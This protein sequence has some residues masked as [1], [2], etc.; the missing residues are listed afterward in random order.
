MWQGLKAEARGRKMP[1][2]LDVYEAALSSRGIEGVKE[3]L[4]ARHNQRW[5]NIQRNGGE[6]A[7]QVL[8][9]L[10][11]AGVIQLVAE[12]IGANRLRLPA[13]PYGAPIDHLAWGVDGVTSAC[14]MLLAGQ[15]FGAAA[16]A[17]TQ[18]ERWSFNLAHGLGVEFDFNALGTDQMR[19]LWDVHHLHVDIADIWNELSELLHG[20]GRYLPLGRWETLDLMDGPAP[21]ALSELTAALG[22]ILVQ[23]R[24]VALGQAHGLEMSAASG[25]LRRWPTST[26]FEAPM[27]FPIPVLSSAGIWPLLHNHVAE[28]LTLVAAVAP[29]SARFCASRDRFVDGGAAL[30]TPA[31]LP[32]LVLAD[33]RY[34][35]WHSAARSF[36]AEAVEVGPLFNPD[37]IALRA[38]HLILTAEAAALTSTWALPQDGA[39]ALWIAASSV[40]SAFFLWLEDDDRALACVRTA[41]ESIAR[42]RAWRT[43]PARALT[44][45]PN[46]IAR[47][48]FELAGWR[49]LRLVNRSLGE[50]SHSMPASRWSGARAALIEAIPPHEEGQPAAIAR[51]A[52][53]RTAIALLGIET[54][55]WLRVQSAALAD[56][57]REILV[58]DQGIEIA[59]EEQWLNQVWSAR[60][61]D[62]G[63]PDFSF[64]SRAVS[65][66]R[67]TL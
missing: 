60:E 66:M 63:D 35:A 29:P 48:W 24:S 57:L 28:D 17:R 22:P 1:P 38:Q 23:L 7:A 19:G 27:D 59:D 41:L 14:R 62:F 45:R 34:R 12:K 16:L 30:F 33:H 67:D 61:V 26:A 6:N 37:V 56:A 64:V 58:E 52:A 5:G 11:P 20:R 44:I 13:S 65:P 4:Y 50:L 25:L 49:R 46:A 39:D 36:D 53:V 10:G 15:A 3:G 9:V 43:K 51:G 42:A 54:I 31:E 18:L 21:N 47:D 32:G 8:P 2:R 55:E 40:R